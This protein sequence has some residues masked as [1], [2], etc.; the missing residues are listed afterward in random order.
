MIKIGKIRPAARHI[1]T[2]GEEL[3]LDKSAAI[4]ELVKNAYDA[5][6]QTVEIKIFQENQIDIEI[7]D[8]GFGMTESDILQKW[9]VPSTTSKVNAME[10]PMGRKVQG[11]KGIGRYS[12]GILGNNISI[13]THKL[14]FNA[15]SL[16]LDMEEFL[17]KQFLD[18]INIPI[19]VS[20]TME[21]LG[22]NIRITS[23]KEKYLWSLNEILTLITSLKKLISPLHFNNDFKIFLTIEAKNINYNFSSE[24]EP[25]DIFNYFDYKISGCVKRN[26]KYEFLFS[27][28]KIK[29][30][31]TKIIGEM[32]PSK[33]GNITFDIRVFDR[34]KQG[35]EQISRRG[36]KN[37]ENSYLRNAE[38]RKLL[39]DVNGIGVYRNGFRIRPLGDPEYDWI[40]L[41]DSRI[42]NPTMKI[43]INQT[44][45][46]VNI[47]SENLSGLEEKSARDGLKDND[48]YQDLIN[49]VR[50][51]ISKL[52]EERY[53][54]RR[55]LGLNKSSKELEKRINSLFEYEKLIN[56]VQKK[57]SDMDVSVDAANSIKYLLEKDF[58]E[59]N[60]IANEIKNTIAIYQGQATLGKIINIVLHEGRR[61]LQY[62]R[63]HR[64]LFEF[65]LN[66][67][68]N[69]NDIRSLEEC[70]EYC[71]DYEKNTD[72]LISLFNKIDP[73]AA[74]KRSTRTKVDL[75][76]VAKSA[77]EIFQSKLSELK[78]KIVIKASPN[79]CYFGWEQDFYTIFVNLIDNSIYWLSTMQNED[80]EILVEITKNEEILNIIFCDNGPGIDECL[81]NDSLIFEPEFTTKPG[82]T[83]LGL[84]ICG[85]AA[86]RNNLNIKA[87]E[88]DKGA[89]FLIEEIKE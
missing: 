23:D 74:K 72:V 48:A 53:S 46:Y 87:I 7:K 8:D 11:R 56:Q 79:I 1:I 25:F 44:I 35:L 51:A 13:T 3:I 66:A 81:L 33:C 5:D 50:F 58:N 34:D 71:I 15:C 63:D 21:Y 75:H 18:E 73:L 84:A 10:T 4:I 22:T 26:G 43:S 60:K 37:D 24:I 88:W 59:K 57:L 80:K 36:L 42:N 30:A 12:A 77:F 65:K 76:S 55:K 49:I 16:K 39:D 68:K 62:F 6:A 86:K 47:E 78:I 41:N 38:V 17:D 61:P 83:G 70:L 27:T 40:K 20:D 19:E 29:Q 89:Y 32:N 31:D 52:E 67:Y 2:I 54:I 28:Q 45:G 82:G 85:E 14:G 64:G 69:N 9:L